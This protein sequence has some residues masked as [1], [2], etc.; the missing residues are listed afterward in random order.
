LLK[1]QQSILTIT[2]VPSAHSISTARKS[3]SYLPYRGMPG[4]RVSTLGTVTI[5]ESP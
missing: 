3:V 1:W 5:N 2:S 4:Y